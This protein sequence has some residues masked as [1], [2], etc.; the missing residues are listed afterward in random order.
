ML[1]IGSEAMALE[2]R[3][4]TAISMVLNDTIIRSDCDTGRWGFATDLTVSELLKCCRQTYYN[5]SEGSTGGWSS[6]WTIESLALA[7]KTLIW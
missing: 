3:F 7:S 5:G 2:L 4:I 6:A 1:S